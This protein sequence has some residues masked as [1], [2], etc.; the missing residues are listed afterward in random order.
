MKSCIAVVDFTVTNKRKEAIDQL[1]GCYDPNICVPPPTH[2]LKLQLH[3]PK[4]TVL[5]SDGV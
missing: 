1:D 5:A 4:A 3:L 2:V